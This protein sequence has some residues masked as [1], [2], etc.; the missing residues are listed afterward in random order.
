MV[1]GDQEAAGAD[2]AGAGGGVKLGAADVGA[3]GGIAA[4]CVAEAFELAAAD[5]FEEDAVG[6]GGGGSVEVDGDAVAAPDL[7]AGLAGEDGALGEGAPL[8]G[9]KGMTSAAPMRG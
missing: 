2:G 8:T 1:V 3:A 5:I 9:T 7:E 4:G 6:T